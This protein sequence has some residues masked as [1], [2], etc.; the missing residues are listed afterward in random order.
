MFAALT[1]TLRVGLAILAI[2]WVLAYV[3]GMVIGKARPDRWRRFSPVGKV[4]MMLSALAVALVGWTAI[5]PRAADGAAIPWIA[6]GL[7]L[8]LLG[9]VTLAGLLPFE[10]PK[11]PG[12]AAFGLGHISY[13]VALIILASG[14]SVPPLLPWGALAAAAAVEALA[15]WTFVRP[16]GASG[17]VRVGTLVYGMLLFGVTAF[18]GALWLQGAAPGVLPLGL[19]LFLASDLLWISEMIELWRFPYIGD[20]IWII[21]SSGQLLIALT[22]VALVLN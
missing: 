2:L 5:T 15:W 22:P 19:V 3:L 17:S 21:Y 9:D 1:L 18:A 10:N 6:A 4:V 13:L 16:S 11:V 8:G 7:L 20:V 12:I 14:S